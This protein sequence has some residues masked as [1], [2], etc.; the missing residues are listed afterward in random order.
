M[1]A[2]IDED[3]RA[4]LR[5]SVPDDVREVC[6]VLQAGGFEAVTVGGAVRDALL[7]RA[8]GD[9]DV[10][11]SAH[12]DEV[13]ARF[14]R[15]IP[16]GLQHGTVTVMVGKG[17]SRQGV[18][19]TTF[20]GEGAY[21]DAR[22]PDSVTFG[23]PLDED[24]ARR[25]FVINAIAYDPIADAIHDPFGGA[26]DLAARI[27]RAV[28]D[29]VARFTEDGLRVMRAVRFAAVLG[30]AL[31]AATE[32]AIPAAL[33]SLAKVSMERVHDELVKLM[34]A[35]RPSAGLAIARRAG[36]F[37]VIAPELAVL[38]EDTLA[39]VDAVRDPVLRVAALWTAIGDR[40]AMAR[41]DERAAAQGD[42]ALAR[43][44]EAAMKRLKFSNEDR[45]RIVRAARVWAAPWR[46]TWSDAGVRRVVAGV[47]R[48][49]AADAI[50]LWRAGGGTEL[51]ARAEASLAAE[52]ALAPGELAIGGG[53][54]MALLGIPP[55]RRVGEIIAAL[56]ERVIEEP[57]LN[58]RE[59]LSEIVKAM[60]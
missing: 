50:A 11:T 39:L 3:A 45:D 21:S 27:V 29:P 20:R 22:R 47:G 18:E 19:V 9:W 12:P 25:D 24:L 17:A 32:A 59:A 8:P 33:G 57:G 35:P 5:T 7:G 43:A 31:D 44:V 36:V 10:A 53:D 13:I 23:V 60:G 6:R 42:A 34:G 46:P 1:P 54:V 52:E 56:M 15:T 55:G 41:G 38:G 26:A 4:R 16:T 2:P 58:T 28:G 49:R 51:A 40:E 14:K 48:A 37:G 30:F